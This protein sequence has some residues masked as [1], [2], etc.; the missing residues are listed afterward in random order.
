MSK[1]MKSTIHFDYEHHQN[2]ITCRNTNF[3]ELTTL[4]NITLTLMMENSYEILN[5]SHVIF[6]DTS[7]SDWEVLKRISRRNKNHCTTV[8]GNTKL[9]LRT[10]N[11]ADQLSVYG[12]V[13][14]W[15]L[16]LT[17]KIHS[18]VDRFIFT[19]TDQLGSVRSW[20]FDEKL[21]PNRRSRGKLLTRSLVT[22]RNMNPD[23]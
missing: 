2:L 6:R 19:E 4:F 5:L 13:S 14:S 12:A 23:S 16:D 1:T 11:S 10:I 3:E 22:T 21:I 7:A 8:S 9:M 17:E 18:G 15:R 20:F